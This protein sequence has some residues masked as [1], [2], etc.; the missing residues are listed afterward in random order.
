MALTTIAKIKT[1]YAPALGTEQDSELT[2]ALGYAD[3]WLKRRTN[4]PMESASYTEYFSGRGQETLA[5][6]PGRQPVLH[7][8]TTPVT[9]TENGS[10][11]TLATGYNTSAHAILEGVNEDR[12]C[13]LHSNQSHFTSGVQNIAVTYTAG[14]STIPVDVEWLASLLAWHIFS[15]KA[16]QG[17]ASA[18]A[19]RGSVSW[20]K[21]LPQMALDLIEALTVR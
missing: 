12:Q 9:A 4:R 15:T 1:L 8:S 14:W 2:A 7:D 17:K 19:G 11:L 5:L 16:W 6:R 20:E 3:A 13:L 18:T 10:S 21:D